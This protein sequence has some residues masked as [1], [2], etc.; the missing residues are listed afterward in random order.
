LIDDSRFIKE[1]IFKD[2]TLIIDMI[3]VEYIIPQ[4][5]MEIE[6]IN[7]SDILN[8]VKKEYLRFDPYRIKHFK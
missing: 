4:R 6:N 3:K 2:E 1:I 5:L 7:E 8:Y